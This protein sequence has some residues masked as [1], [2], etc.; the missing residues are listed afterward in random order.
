[1]VLPLFDRLLVDI[2]D[3]QSIA[4]DLPRFRRTMLNLKSMLEEATPKSLVL[5]DEMGT[6]TA[7][8]E[9]ARWQWRCWTNFTR[10]TALCWPT[11]H[12]DR[13]KTYAS[14]TPG[15]LNA[16]VEFDDV[17]LRPTFRLMVGVPG[18]SSGIAIAQRLG[19][20]DR[21]LNRRA[22]S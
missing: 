14:T 12:H 16:A 19:L 15:V 9:G 11:T 21:S 4:A 7:P 20:A 17:N 3:E 5:V 18:G 8:E 2:G 22:R 13:L 6:G 1:V 10:K